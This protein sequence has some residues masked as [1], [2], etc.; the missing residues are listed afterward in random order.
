MPTFAPGQNRPQRLITFTQSLRH[1]MCQRD[2]PVARTAR[3][4]HIL[5]VQSQRNIVVES[6]ATLQHVVQD[7][8]L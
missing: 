2:F 4:F 7:I 5:V 1:V 6:L 3:L 8:L